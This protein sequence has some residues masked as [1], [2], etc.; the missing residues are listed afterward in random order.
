MKVLLTGGAG[1]I[2]STIAAAL[3]DAGDDPV[4]LDDLSRGCAAFLAPYPSYVGDVADARLVARIFADHPD[5]RIAIHCAA[6]TVVSDSLADPLGYYRENVA[7]TIEFVQ[8]LL[9]HGCTRLIFSSSAAVYGRVATPVVTEQSPLAPASPYATSKVMVEQVLADVCQA[10]ALSAL[11]LRYFN[12][13]G[14]D[15]ALR[16]GPYDPRPLDA[17]GSLLAAW[18]NGR[19]FCIHGN[20]WPTSDG[21]PIRDFVH[22]WDVANAHVAAAKTWA[23]N[24]GAG[25]EVLNIGSGRGT[26]VRQLADTFNA[27]VGSPVEIR[28]DGRRAGDTVGAYT[29]TDRA[30]QLLGWHP[31]RTVAQAVVDTLG[32]AARRAAALAPNPCR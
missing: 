17:I 20:D 10:S 8:S 29:M 3:H 25:H 2:G 14:C 9:R 15:P 26:T 28:Y 22:V 5:I 12:P 11:S 16:S 7:K 18:E 24:E 13:I 19:P 27:H 23:A 21:T 32:W 4:L 1:Y 31:G 30:E 6:R